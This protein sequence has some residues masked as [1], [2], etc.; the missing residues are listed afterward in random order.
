MASPLPM[1]LRREWAGCFF[2]VGRGK[3]TSERHGRPCKIHFLA[4]FVH[5]TARPAPVLMALRRDSVEDL[6]FSRP[7]GAP[8]RPLG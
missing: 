8:L 6:T 4:F 2:G 1:K 3:K 5:N 7:L